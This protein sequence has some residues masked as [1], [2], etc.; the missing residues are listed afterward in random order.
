MSQWSF[1][2]SFYNSVSK[3]SVTE[4]ANHFFFAAADYFAFSQGE[5]QAVFSGVEK[6]SQH[7]KVEGAGIGGG[8]PATKGTPK[9]F[10]S[11]LGKHVPKSDSNTEL[12]VLLC[13]AF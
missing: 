13:A 5:T 4:A 3:K 8:Y 7:F 6:E 11:R 12:S 2:N 10:F 1:Q 9:A